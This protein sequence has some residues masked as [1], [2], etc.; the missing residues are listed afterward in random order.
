MSMAENHRRL[1]QILESVAELSSAERESYI[2]SHCPS[3]EMRRQVRSLLVGY[4]ESGNDFL[5]SLEAMSIDELVNELSPKQYDTVDPAIDVNAKTAHM[6]EYLRVAPNI[7]RIG[8]REVLEEIARGGMGVVYKVRHE[9]LGR[10]EALKMILGGA[11]ASDETIAR[12][13]A[14]AKAAANLDHPGIVKIH[15]SGIHDGLPYFSME[16]VEGRSLGDLI[17]DGPLPAREA[18]E[19][20]GKIARAIGYAHAQGVLHRDIKPANVIVN[21]DG[22]PRITDFGLA[23]QIDSGSNLTL[24]NQVMGTPSYMPP[25]QAEGRMSDVSS[26]SD[27]YSVG[28]VL[29]AMLTGRPPFQGENIRATLDQVVTQQA[30]APRQLNSAVPKDLETIC[31]KCLRKSP[32]DR[33]DSAQALAED[34]TRFLNGEPI[35]ARPVGRLEKGWSWCKSNPLV[36]VLAVL[37]ALTLVTGITVSTFNMLKAWSAE[38]LAE[39]KAKVALHNEK[40]AESRRLSTVAAQQQAEQESMRAVAEK[41][42]AERQRD[43]AEWLLYAQRIH[44]AKQAWD[45]NQPKLAWTY[46]N[47]CRWDFRG[48][49]HDY[50]YTQFSKGMVRFSNAVK[51]VSVC[52]TGQYVAVAE[53]NSIRIVNLETLREESTLLGH[54]NSVRSVAYSPNG[55][56]IVSGSWDGEMRIW[57]ARKGEVLYV[58]KAHRGSVETVSFS[59]DSLKVVSG[60]RDQTCKVWDAENGKQIFIEDP[61]GNTPVTDNRR[62]IT[63]TSSIASAAFSPDNERIVTGDFDGGVKVFHATT[64]QRLLTLKGQQKSSHWV[65]FSPDGRWIF[66]AQSRSRKRFN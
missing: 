44:L 22:E 37:V 35:H 51:D 9:G 60:G 58:S 13:Y 47:S 39:Q 55:A 49:E 61:L 56:L 10:T 6:A 59:S 2:E 5:A 43:R 57:D 64:G 63:N 31:L 8:E 66:A 45:N 30:V 3:E 32:P 52:P 24:T 41:E 33:Y 16:Y 21:S 48:W 50:L 38:E 34:L 15:D 7:Q 40:L 20:A 54:S 23:K 19:Y 25:E 65:A 4:D 17:E 29:Y 36:A 18:A 26:T 12:F 28:G 53:G 1:F 11:H 42:L 14:E 46:L 62:Q 27:V